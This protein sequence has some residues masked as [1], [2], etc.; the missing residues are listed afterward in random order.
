[1]PATLLGGIVINE[2]LVDPNGANN[3]DTDGNGTAAA[4]D[5]FVELYN[6]SS[7]AIDI[8]GLELWDD[9][10]GHWFTFP[11]ESELQPDARAVVAVG[12]QTGGSLPTGGPDDLT[13]DN[14]RGSAVINN[15]GDNVVVYDPANDEFIQATFNGDAA[16]DPPNDYA[17]F[18]ATAT[19]SG[20]TEDFG[21]D[22]DGLSLQRESDGNTD[23]TSDTP[24]PGT[25]NVCFADG[26]VLAT[27]QGEIAIEDLTPGDR[28]L[29]SDRGAQTVRWVYRKTWSRAQVLADPRRRPVCIRSGSFG[30]GLPRRDLLVSQQ[31]RILV[32]GPIVRRMFDT[33]QVFL[34]A[35][36]LLHL[37]GVGL[38]VP[39]E[40][41][42]Y[43]HILLDHHEVLF[44][45]GIAAESLHLGPMAVASIPPAAL[46]EVE[47]L[48]G[49]SIDAL[50]R[51]LARPNS[52]F[53]K[54]T[55]L[56]ERHVKNS[57]PLQSVA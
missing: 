8:S 51:P 32:S 48:L 46:E 7:S 14:G 20:V 41:V 36:S 30:A 40:S 35:K 57:R 37:S 3:F 24:T 2:I 38:I 4:N 22:T 12:V 52:K 27:S 21:N 53:R 28:L 31:H 47:T 10:V 42:S 44:A 29:T 56:V 50:S 11:P 25:V 49:A 26:T 18:S 9:G 23:V 1:M 17:G 15:G 5:E 16:D 13:F 55:R 6:T 54:A 43:Y 39:A 45:N 33:D 34:P 19:R